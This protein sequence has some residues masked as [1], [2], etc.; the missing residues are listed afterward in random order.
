VSGPVKG[1]LRTRTVMA[2]DCGE[3]MEINSRVRAAADLVKGL[4]VASVLD[5]GCRTCEAKR[6]V[7]TGAEYFGN[8]LF[9]NDSGSVAFVG[10]AVDI[11]F[12]RTFDCVMALDV[13]EHLDNPYHLLEKIISLADKYVIVSLPNV[14]DLQHKYDFVVKNSLGDKYLFDVK[15]RLDRH[16]WLMN[17]DEIYRFFDF[18]KSKYAMT[19]TTSDVALGQFSGRVTSR[20]GGV[21]LRALLGKKVMTRTVIARFSKV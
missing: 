16:R 6:I 15:N 3:N 9:Q 21:V 7:P 20:L 8:D 12:G 19:M 5:I 10:D 17:Y 4:P 13:I 2:V 1:I 14:Y 18:Y 11:D